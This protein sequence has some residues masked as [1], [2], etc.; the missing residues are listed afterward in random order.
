MIDFADE[1]TLSSSRWLFHKTTRREQYDRLYRE[2]IRQGLFDFIFCNERGEVT[3]GCISNLVVRLDGR[4]Y[5]PPQE[6][7]LLAGT[8]RRQLLQQNRE[9]QVK[10]RP[11]Y[12]EDLERAEAIYLCNSVRGIVRV[13][14]R[15]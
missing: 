8:M 2:A 5:T 10:Q 6:S 12:R 4:Y 7:G 3:E 1:Q 11:L 14:L 13:R 9:V 15:G